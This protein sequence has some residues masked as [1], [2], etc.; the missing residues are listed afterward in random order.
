MTLLMI[1]DLSFIKWTGHAGFLLTLNGKN[2]Y[3]DPFNLGKTR[4]H[5]DVI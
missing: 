1:M 2:V 5:A 3:I 4:D